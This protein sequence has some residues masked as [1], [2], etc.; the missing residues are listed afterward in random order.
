[1]LGYSVV[2]APS[3][4]ATHLSELFRRHAADM[5]GRQDVQH[6]LNSLKADYPVVVDDL[7]NGLMTLGE[8]QR[9]LQSLLLERVSIRD[10]LTICETLATHARITKDPDALTEQ[11]RLALA[12][13]I[14]TQYAGED[15]VLKVITLSPHLEQSLVA[16]LQPTDQGLSILV[17]PGLA[18]RML[19]EVSARMES[20]AAMGRPPVLLCSGRLRRPFRRLAERVFPNLV[21]LAFGEVTAEVDVESVGVVDVGDTE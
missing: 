4:I 10:L 3:V 17:D 13:S 9:V 21:V 7:T 1:V 8:I 12:R 18:N 19:V 2:D 15:R 6:L 11:V 20:L 5:L 14:C 16:S